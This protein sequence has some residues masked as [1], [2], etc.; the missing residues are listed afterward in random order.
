MSI[1]FRWNPLTVSRPVY[2]SV[3]RNWSLVRDLLTLRLVVP[4]IGSAKSFKLSSV[5]ILFFH[6]C[7]MTA[8]CRTHFSFSFLKASLKKKIEK[9]KDHDSTK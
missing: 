7:S 8:I 3:L 4:P 9:S 2:S 1:L 5:M 6:F